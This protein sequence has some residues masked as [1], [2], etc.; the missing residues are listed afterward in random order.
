MKD[1]LIIHISTKYWDS[2]FKENRN[3]T[4]RSF[5]LIIIYVFH[6]FFILLMISFLSLIVNLCIKS[7]IT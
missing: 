7:E 1:T 4:Q 5:E 3:L 6:T 2:Y